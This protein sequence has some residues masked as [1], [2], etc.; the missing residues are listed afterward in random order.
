MTVA[1]LFGQMATGGPLNEDGDEVTD[2]AVIEG[3]IAAVH[4]PLYLCSGNLRK[5]LQHS[6][7]N[8][9][10][11]VLLGRRAPGIWSGTGHELDSS[12]RS[13]WLAVRPFRTDLIALARVL[14]Q[15]FTDRHGIPPA[16]LVG[17]IDLD[18]GHASR[19]VRPPSG[20][21]EFLSLTCGLRSVAA[22][23]RTD[24]AGGTT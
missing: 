10:D 19:G 1:I 8:A 3:V 17:A 16:K 6:R 4:G 15:P 14:C 12:P 13:G 23:G 5:L 2:S 22:I 11:R 9:A 24:R 7:D 21:S 18:N 20:S